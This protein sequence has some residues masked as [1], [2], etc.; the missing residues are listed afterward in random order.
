MQLRENR[1]AVE[2]DAQ[3]PWELAVQ[4]PVAI[5]VFAV[6]ALAD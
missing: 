1:V 2:V 6:G 5:A 3:E 4:E